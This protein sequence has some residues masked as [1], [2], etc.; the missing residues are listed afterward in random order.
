MH[1]SLARISRSC[2]PL[3][4]RDSTVSD[5]RFFYDCA[6]TE[7]EVRVVKGQGHFLHTTEP[8]PTA[9]AIVA[10]LTPPEAHHIWA[11]K[12]FFITPWQE[13]SR[14]VEF[15]FRLVSSLR[16][17]AR[18]TP[19]LFPPPA[20]IQT[21]KSTKQR[22][23]VLPAVSTSEDDSPSVSPRS[24]VAA[25]ASPSPSHSVVSPSST[26]SPSAPL[27]FER[28]GEMPRPFSTEGCKTP[29]KRV[30]KGYMDKKAADQASK[31]RDRQRRFDTLFFFWVPEL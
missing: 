2:P 1:S 9:S 24:G 8:R 7:V 28:I 26:I 6:I 19:D 23:R 29:P 22:A 30:G 27:C 31:M 12:V 3:Q 5:A 4:H 25:L 18:V 10:L 15:C 17:V 16:V 20:V 11:S 21:K 13:E 14:N